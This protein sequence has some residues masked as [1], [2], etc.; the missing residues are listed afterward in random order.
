MCKPGGGQRGE[1]QFTADRPVGPGIEIN[2][3][4]GRAAGRSRG[5]HSYRLWEAGGWVTGVRKP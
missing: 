5:P 1:S 4:Q 3:P 2:V